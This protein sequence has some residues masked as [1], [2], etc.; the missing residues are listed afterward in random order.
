MPNTQ[1]YE[2]AIR[3]DYIDS[4]TTT[5]LKGSGPAKLFRVVVNGG[6]SA[7]GT[8]TIYNNASAAGL[9]V[10]IID[11]ATARGNSQEFGFI[12]N[13]INGLTILTE[14]FANGANCTIVY[15]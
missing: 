10:A 15:Q 7:A 14:S 11:V 3:H 2:E 1:R 8:I 6:S 4:S 13:N 9:V 12:F 5:V